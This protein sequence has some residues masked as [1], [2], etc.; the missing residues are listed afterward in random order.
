[1]V[2]HRSQAGLPRRDRLRDTVCSRLVGPEQ[3]MSLDFNVSSDWLF[4]RARLA[5]E[6]SRNLVAALEDRV[7]EAKGM[8]TAYTAERLHVSA[9]PIAVR[10][11]LAR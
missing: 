9:E 5:C 2:D 6:E 3:D 10:G 7:A 11:A 8:V 1:M 4:E